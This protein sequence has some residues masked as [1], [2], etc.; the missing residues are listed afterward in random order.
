[1]PPPA[2]VW[3]VVLRSSRSAVTPATERRPA[4]TQIE[5]RPFWAGPLPSPPRTEARLSPLSRMAPVALAELAPPARAHGQ[6]HELQRHGLRHGLPQGLPRLRGPVHPGSLLLGGEDAPDPGLP[7]LSGLEIPGHPRPVRRQAK[8]ADDEGRLGCLA[9][10]RLPRLHVFN[11]PSPT[12]RGEPALLG[13]DVSWP[14]APQT[15]N[16]RTPQ[17][18]QARKAFVSALALRCPSVPRSRPSS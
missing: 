4:R 10:R 14:E 3:G 9:P 13:R 7:D 15:L 18:A 5:S 1:M 11:R 12:T 6:R 2:R 17:H 8:G 16:R